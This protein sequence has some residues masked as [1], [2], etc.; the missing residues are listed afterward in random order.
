MLNIFSSASQ[1]FS[2]PQLRI[3]CLALYPILK[4]F[5]VFIYLFLLGTFFIHISSAIP[6]V[7]H[8]LPPPPPP[9]PTFRPWSSPALRHMLNISPLS[10]LGL[11]KILFQSVGG[12][13]VLL[14]VSFALQKLCNFMSHPIIRHQSRHYCL[15]QQDFAERTLI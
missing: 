12:L 14:T 15:C 7:P 13:F 6:K 5:L 4:I 10:D 11:V 3:L 1:P 2:I 9:T 8:T